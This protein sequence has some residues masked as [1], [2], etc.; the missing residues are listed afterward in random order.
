MTEEP[1]LDGKH[2][3]IGRRAFWF[4]F[5]LQLPIL[6]MWAAGYKGLVLPIWVAINWLLI[7]YF[8]WKTTTS[9][10]R[11]AARDP[12]NEVVRKYQE[13]P[14]NFL[15][16]IPLWI[17]FLAMAKIAGSPDAGWWTVHAAAAC[18]GLIFAACLA[19]GIRRI[20]I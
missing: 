11:I 4:L 13:K 9:L 7:I 15:L 3:R 8:R 5:L 16:P 17:G 19:D 20:R 10:V 1:I 2:K 14:W 6:F 12:A 18:L